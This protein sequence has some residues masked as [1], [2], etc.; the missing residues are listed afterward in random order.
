[1]K[2]LSGINFRNVTIGA[3]ILLILVVVVVSFLISYPLMLLWNIALV[4]A[5]T[6]LAEVSWLQMW[7]ISILLNLMINGIGFSTK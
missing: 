3:W 5:V 7:G 1:M 2:D 4:P 6:V